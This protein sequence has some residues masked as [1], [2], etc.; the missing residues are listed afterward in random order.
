MAGG[1]GV[2][3]GPVL[4]CGSPS[5]QSFTFM[6]KYIAFAPVLIC[7]LFCI[8]IFC[9][10]HSIKNSDRIRIQGSRACLHKKYENKKKGL[11]KL[12]RIFTQ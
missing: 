8:L 2:M 3:T 9:V 4:N 7:L 12:S 10:R 11:A 1:K 6:V 5:V